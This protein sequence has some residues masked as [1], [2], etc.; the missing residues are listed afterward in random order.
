ML[1]SH[2]PPVLAAHRRLG[3]AHRHAREAGR[4]VL[5]QGG[6]VG[7]AEAVQGDG[8]A[9]LEVGGRGV[10]DDALWG[11]ATSDAP[12][13]QS[14]A[15]CPPVCASRRGW[16]GLRVGGGASETCLPH[17]VGGGRSHRAP[18]W[19][20]RAAPAD[21]QQSNG[22]PHTGETATRRGEAPGRARDTSW[23]TILGHSHVPPAALLAP[24]EPGSAHGELAYPLRR[25]KHGRQRGGARAK[26][27][28]LG[29]Q[30]TAGDTTHRGPAAH[31]HAV[32]RV[33]GPFHG[34]P[35]GARRC[36]P[37]GKL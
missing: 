8:A 22:V 34:L 1:H 36:A 5:T 21:W 18:G 9:R 26:Q 2:L 25:E 12:S 17:R 23:R 19:P 7:V 14:P 13:S 3:A 24:H 32:E 10:R 31:K 11:A 35:E 20:P 28:K 33:H 16:P 37:R 27:G 4:E 15:G 6:H 29:F 30:L